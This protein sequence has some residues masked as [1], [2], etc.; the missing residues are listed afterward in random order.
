MPEDVTIDHTWKSPEAE[1]VHRDLIEQWHLTGEK[2][3]LDEATRIYMICTDTT[4]SVSKEISERY[5]LK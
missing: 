3:F 4:V 1:K 5:F 2:I